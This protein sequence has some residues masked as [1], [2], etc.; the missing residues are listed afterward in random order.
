MDKRN[1]V[2]VAVLTI[3]SVFLM[4]SALLMHPFGIPARNA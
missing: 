2:A 4:F 3:V 1:L